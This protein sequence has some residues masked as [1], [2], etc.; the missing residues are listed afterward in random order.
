MRDV[1]S[2]EKR[3]RDANGTASKKLR[4]LFWGMTGVASEK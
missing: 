1:M 2:A 3:R 4:I